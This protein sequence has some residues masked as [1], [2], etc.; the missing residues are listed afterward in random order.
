MMKGELTTEQIIALNSLRKEP[1]PSNAKVFAEYF[2]LGERLV[3]RRIEEFHSIK[4]RNKKK[5]N[6]IK[7]LK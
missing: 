7:R 1:K 5:L 4:G 6:N 3:W 2:N